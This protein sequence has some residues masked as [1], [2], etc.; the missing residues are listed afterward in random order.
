MT[1]TEK[2]REQIKFNSTH[3]DVSVGDWII[4]KDESD[5]FNIL[6]VDDDSGYVTVEDMSGHK[7]TIAKSEVVRKLTNEEVH[8]YGKK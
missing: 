8:E 6:Q 2:W 3:K 4:L 7:F 5:Y 1:G